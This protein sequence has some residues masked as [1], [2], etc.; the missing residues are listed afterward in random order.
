MNID[1]LPQIG[2]RDVEIGDIIT[3]HN[4]QHFTSRLI[5]FGEELAGQWDAYKRGLPAPSHALIK[6][7]DYYF[8]EADWGDSRFKFFPFWRVDAGIREIHVAELMKRSGFHVAWR[9]KE[10][11][12]NAKKRIKEYLRKLG[13][14]RIKYDFAGL[15]SVAKETAYAIRQKTPDARRAQDPNKFF[16]SELVA[17]VLF[18][19]GGIENKTGL[20][21]YQ[22]SPAL[23][24]KM[25][26]AKMIGR[27]LF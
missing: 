5:A 11:D 26:D 8:T 6:T 15:L 3:Y 14:R 27:L 9:I 18:K 20:F 2:I 23:L 19:Q 7:G 22:I 4:S 13:A 10:L 12:P 21:P 24:V 16:C 1:E 25:T 17:E